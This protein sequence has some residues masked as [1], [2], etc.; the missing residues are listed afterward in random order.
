[1]RLD[2]ETALFRFFFSTT[3]GVFLAGFLSEVP[4]VLLVGFPG[5][6]PQ[7]LLLEYPVWYP[8]WAPLLAV[9]VGF[10]A[11]APL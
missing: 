3:Q 6:F 10:Q 1:M 2:I 9:P 4:R 11:L 7:V 5:E 8:G